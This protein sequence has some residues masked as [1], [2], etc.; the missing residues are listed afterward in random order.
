MTTR[1]ALYY[2]LNLTWGLPMTL[3]GFL[4]AIVLLTT[5]H[6]PSKY[7]GALHF[8]VGEC[9]GGVSL[10]LVILTDNSPYEDVVSHEFG[11]TLQNAMFGPFMIIL[12]CIPSAIRYWIFELRYRIK[13][14]D[15]TEGYD[16]IWFEAQA[17]KFG[18]NI[19]KNW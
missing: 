15:P 13:G 6:K 5:K 10:G 4:V 11:H 14:I 16:D 3:V 7:A 18:K 2:I 19:S 17:T 9:W 12:V 8:K 1:K